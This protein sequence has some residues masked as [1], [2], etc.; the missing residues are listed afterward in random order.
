MAERM[1]KRNKVVIDKP[2][3]S[4]SKSEI[5]VYYELPFASDIIK[6][7]DKIKIKNT[8]GMFIFNRLVHNISLNVQWVDCLD[9]KTGMYRSFYT[10]KINSVVRPKRSRKKRAKQ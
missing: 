4:G 1:T 3:Y 8:R 9:P 2:E 5:V 6:P 10:N 7:G